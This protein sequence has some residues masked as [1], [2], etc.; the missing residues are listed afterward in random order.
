MVQICVSINVKT[1]FTNSVQEHVHRCSWRHFASDGLS[2]GT[3]DMPGRSQILVLIFKK[4]FVDNSSGK[5][6][7]I[8]RTKEKQAHE[9]LQEMH[10]DLSHLE[11]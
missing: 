5:N 7:I 11:Y 3:C 2:D 1:I 6:I 9:Q 8:P 4:G 10:V